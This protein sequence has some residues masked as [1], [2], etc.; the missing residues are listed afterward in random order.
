MSVVC[1][2]SIFQVVNPSWRTSY[3]LFYIF[4]CLLV[5]LNLVPEHVNECSPCL[6]DIKECKRRSSCSLFYIFDCL[7]PALNLDL[8]HVNQCGPCLRGIKEC[9]YI[10]GNCT[11]NT[12]IQH[13]EQ[14]LRLTP[15]EAVGNWEDGISSGIWVKYLLP[16][17]HTEVSPLKYLPAPKYAVEAL[18]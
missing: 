1:T 6:N 12:P 9:E 13:T 14:R 4:N 7:L 16:C 2:Q 17:E 10:S 8:K 15:D 11:K 5:A 3:S 18:C